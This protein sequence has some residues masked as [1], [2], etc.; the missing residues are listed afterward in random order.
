MKTIVPILLMVFL[1][2]ISFC[3]QSK[4]YS[5]SLLINN[6]TSS[7]NE[8][9]KEILQNLIDQANE[10]Q[11]VIDSLVL[12]KVLRDAILW[13]NQNA[14]QE[15]F[16][17]KYEVSNDS[18]AVKVEISLDYYFTRTEPHL[19]I[20]R[21]APS[22]VYIDVYSKNDS[23]FENVLSHQEW[24]MTYVGDTI[25]DVNGD[26]LNDLVVNWYGASGC[27]LKAFSA[28]YLLRNDKRTFARKL[29]FINP[30]FSPREKVIRGV[31]Y[32]QPGETAMYKYKWHGD[33]VDT[34]E[35]VFYEK[36]EAG[37]KTG[38]I[39]IANGLPEDSSSRILQRLNRVPSEY[40]RIEG[41]YWF[42][43]EL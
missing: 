34:L 13:A 3:H 24:F 41:Y 18:T 11:N 42:K 4:N 21:Y 20:K 16:S 31:C 38:L 26:G 23:V 5:N 1:L 27:C 12:E 32:G 9:E 33:N 22:A 10:D 2:T 14:A 37:K 17:E 28:V 35:Y 43:G 25:R 29:E 6:D 15:R 19:I 30:T 7:K 40:E 39:V 36:N 8:Y